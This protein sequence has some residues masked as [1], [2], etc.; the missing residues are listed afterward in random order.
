M[1]EDTGVPRIVSS[2]NTL[3]VRQESNPSNLTVAIIAAIFAV[4]ALMAGAHT[5]G[6]KSG[7]QQGVSDALKFRSTR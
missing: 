4:L 3:E 1:S 7:Y 5:V 6:R 2:C